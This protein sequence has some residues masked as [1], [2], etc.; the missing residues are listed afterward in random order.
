MEAPVRCA[1]VAHCFRRRGCLAR[2]RKHRRGGND[3]GRLV[4]AV[5]GDESHEAAQQQAGA[6][7]QHQRKRHLRHDQYRPRPVRPQ[8]PEP[9]RG[10]R[11]PLVQRAHQMEPRPLQGRNHTRQQPDEYRQA[12]GER[13]R[14]LVDSHLVEPRDITRNERRHHAQDDGRSGQAEHAPGQAQRHA[15]GQELPHEPSSA[16]SERRAHGEHPLARHSAGEKQPR[17]V[18]AGDQQDER[19]S[20]G[21]HQ[22]RGPV[23]AD[24][25]LQ[26]WNYA[27][28]DLGPLTGCLILARSRHETGVARL[29]DGAG[30]RSGLLR[31]YAGT[32]S[33]ERAK[34]EADDRARFRRAVHARRPERWDDQRRPELV[35]RIREVEPFR[36]YA[37]DGIRLAV[38]VDEGSDDVR[39]RSET[40]RPHAV[41]EQHDAV[42][43]V[44]CFLLHE[45]P[46]QLGS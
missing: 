32:K 36:E 25:F 24:H 9:A 31:R 39:I 3:V 10:L 15:L 11:I 12:D 6:D 34:H 8:Q 1:E 21:Q 7:Q 38:E 20:C 2:K 18:D 30:F 43:A 28:I 45:E 27:D 42:R 44:P 33:S 40:T 17:H 46:A 37:D 4:A 16:R 13:N 14:H 29:K 23:L 35:V 22:Q 5:E 19:R 26:Q 41:A